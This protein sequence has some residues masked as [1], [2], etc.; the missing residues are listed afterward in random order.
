LAGNACAWLAK[1][2]HDRS[3]ALLFATRSLKFYLY[4]NGP[5]EAK[6]L[7]TKT[8]WGAHMEIIGILGFVFATVTLGTLVYE[9]EMDVLR[10][11]TIE[12]HEETHEFAAIFNP[13]AAL[14]D[15][16][17]WTARNAVY[18]ASLA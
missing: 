1:P 12:G 9:H 16:L 5:I 8:G 3:I 13:A 6:R 18:F 10:G 15:R 7:Q 4:C 14:V 2:E 11:R 17:N